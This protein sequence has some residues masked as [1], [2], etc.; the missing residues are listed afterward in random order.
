MNILK[1]LKNNFYRIIEKKSIIILAFIIIPIMIIASIIVSDNSETVE[2][3]ALISRDFNYS[4][5]NDQLDIH[6]LAE[7]PKLYE[8]ILGDYD[9][10]VID[11]GNR[12]FNIQ[13]IQSKRTK[14]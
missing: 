5:N 2:H 14:K 10:V 4:I 6:L 3:I 12:Q 13:T 9:A 7:Q 1:I 11:D 8:L